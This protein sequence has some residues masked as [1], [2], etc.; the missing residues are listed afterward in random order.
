V[1]GSGFISFEE[2]GKFIYGDEFENNKLFVE[3]I[4]VEAGKDPSKEIGFE[5]F[6]DILLCL[7]RQS[8]I[9]NEE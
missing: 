9:E 6:K 3:N 8:S 4:I 7:K 5:D 2:I 1:D